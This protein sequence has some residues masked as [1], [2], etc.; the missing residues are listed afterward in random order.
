MRQMKKRHKYIIYAIVSIAY[1]L[2]PVDLIPDIAPVIGS[3][4][5][6]IITLIPLIEGYRSIRKDD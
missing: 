5:D 3:I 4:D 2:A 6:L 1:H